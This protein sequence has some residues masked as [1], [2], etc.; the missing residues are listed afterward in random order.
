MK[1]INILALFLTVAL[2]FASCEDDNF[3]EEKPTTFY[4]LENAFSSSS[5]VDQ[6]LVSLYSHIRDLW[7]NPT[8]SGWIY[9]F[10]G[11]GT[12]MFD[13]PNIRRG[14]CFSDYGNIN[15]DNGNFYELYTTWYYVISRAN[16]AIYAADLPEVRWGSEEEKNYVLAQARFFRAF[17]YKNLGE[18]FGGVPI[19]TDIITTPQYDFSRTGR[20]ETYKFAIE[21]LEAIE[22]NLP[23]TTTQGGRLVRAAAQH[24]LCE[25]YLALGIQYKAEGQDSEATNAYNNAVV[26]GNKV[27]D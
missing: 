15:P 20:I 3:L 14:N 25:L 8:E 11:K 9:V 24:N 1:K 18:L 2:V 21:E 7:T 27:I 13:V 4:T 6:I 5:Q 12:D 22:G 19:V 16:L 10:R 26:N 23:E 17:A